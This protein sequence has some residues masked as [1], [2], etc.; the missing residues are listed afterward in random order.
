VQQ[1]HP[2]IYMSGSSPESGEFAARHHISLG[3][4][5][6]TV[7]LAAKAAAYY[8]EQAVGCGWEPTPDDVLYRLSV[9][10]ADTDQEAIDD[11]LAAGAAERRAGFATSNRALDDTAASLGYYGR[12]VENQRGRLRP[13]DLNERMA[14]GQL[15]AGSPDSVLSQIRALRDEVGCGI[16]DLIFQPV[17]HDKTLKAIE[18]FGRKVLPCMREL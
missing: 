15:L 5:F 4:A 11:L 3:F 7:P 13:H 8:R 17:G 10:V 1:P 9:H 14:L 12:D 6:T 16:L 2:P 18:L